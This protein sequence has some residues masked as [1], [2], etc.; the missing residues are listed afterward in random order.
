MSLA[1]I[2][3]SNLA[4]VDKFVRE[5]PNVE[6]IDFGDND[7]DSERT[8]SVF[9][10]LKFNRL[11]NDIKQGKPDT[12]IRLKDLFK[13]DIFKD[14]QKRAIEEELRNFKDGSG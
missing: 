7:L 1:D 13:E 10:A 2:R 8:S 11:C 12:E 14:Q 9:S 6:S 3:L 4:F 5:F